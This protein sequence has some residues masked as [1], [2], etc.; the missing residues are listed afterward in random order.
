MK[1]WKDNV[2]PSTLQKKCDW[3]KKNHCLDWRLFKSIVK[4]NHKKST[5]ELM[6]VC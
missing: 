4:S 2:E 6:T 1:T 5:V 3:G